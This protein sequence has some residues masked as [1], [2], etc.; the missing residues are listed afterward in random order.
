[1][2]GISSGVKK[3]LDCGSHDKNSNASLGIAM[4]C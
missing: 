4:Q 3:D 2:L 1:V